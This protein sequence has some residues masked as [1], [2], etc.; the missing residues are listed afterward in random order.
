MR[1]TVPRGVPFYSQRVSFSV[2]Q[3]LEGEWIR[4]HSL[5]L[6]TGTTSTVEDFLP[7][8]LRHTDLR[9][10]GL[11]CRL[12]SPLLEGKQFSRLET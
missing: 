4:E 1:V 8:P 5:V 7:S 2:A 12:H 6:T 3:R 10:R 11:R 9:S